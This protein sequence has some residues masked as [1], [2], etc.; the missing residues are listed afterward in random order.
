M[1]P[2][3]NSARVE[4]VQGIP[5]DPNTMFV[6]F[7]SGGLWKTENG[8]LSWKPIFEEN[9]SPGIGD[10]AIA[11]SNPDIIYVGTGESLKKPRN[12]TMPGTGM[13]RSTDGGR[14]W[15]HLGLTETRHISEIS[16]HPT[17]PD[18]VLVA[19]MGNFWTKNADRGIYR[20]SDSGKTWKQVLYVDDKTSGNDVV[21][22]PSN[23]DI[24]YASLWENDPKYSRHL[25]PQS[26]GLSG[27][28]SGVFKSTD[29]GLTWSK[30]N[31]G[32][33]ENENAGRI[34]FGV[35]Y[36]DA[37]KVYAFL[38]HR[39]KGIL[40]GAGELYKTES[41]GKNW[42]KTHKDE[43][44]NLSVIGWYFVDT[45]VNPQD[46][47]E[48]YTLGVR[49]AN[50]RDGGKTFANIGGK[51]YHHYPS[52]AQTLHLD[53][54]EMWINPIDP[55]H[56]IL[57]NDGGVYV[58]TDRGE[59]WK[60]LNNIPTGEFYDITIDNQDPYLIY[61]GTQDNSTVYGPALEWNSK[62]P[63][64]WKYLWIDA[65]SG[66]DGC[67]TFVDP[68]DPKRVYFSMQ[69][70]SIR[71]KD[72]EADTSISIRPKLPDSLQGKFR[73]NFIT[74]YLLSPNNPDKLYLAGN[75]VF[76]SMDQ[77][78]SWNIISSDLSVSSNERKKSHAASAF[79][80]SQ[81]QKGTLYLGTDMGAFWISKDD[82]RTWEERSNGLPNAY[83]RSIY[84]SNHGQN[85]IYLAATGLNYDDLSPYL[86]VTEDMGKGWI[87]IVGN[88]PSEPVNVVHE[89]P[90]FKDVL[91]AGT[92]RGI[93]VSRN[94]GASWSYLG[95]NMP[96]VA[97]ADIEIEPES[98][99]MITAT[100][101]RGIYK[102]NLSPIYEYFE[103]EG[104]VL[105]TI[106][107]AI[108]PKRTD[109][110]ND[111]SERTFSRVPITYWS[112]TEEEIKLE[113]LDQKDSL[114]WST[115]QSATVGLN[116]FR[117][118]LITQKTES[119]SPYFIHYNKF[120]EPG[121]YT[122]VLTQADQSFM[123]ELVVKKYEN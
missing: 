62:F 42:I 22:S 72:I 104:R 46:D 61:G 35:S 54:C 90:K 121:E 109:T 101:G 6:A 53:H 21:I 31:N 74:P 91:Y 28:N 111:Y 107:E 77:G 17:N 123:R 120:I 110:H 26:R 48:I 112:D 89:D 37:D 25:S 4:S 78:T 100:H 115:S 86:F 79:T 12:F 70:G 113:I 88:L 32:I 117:W 51:I 2:T 95:K 47:N 58:T 59:T 40:K 1:G 99:D 8:G 96:S 105:F 81:K 19:A 119:N 118:D 45:Y 93:Y 106:P 85:R 83:I 60:H 20:T 84:P 102:M 67:M 56:Q 108:L 39:N 29:G 23:P 18:I 3:L 64:N 103:N 33:P 52:P 43:L 73:T 55:H 49:L 66:G 7:G 16:V 34:G 114:I 9:P 68:R 27:P 24:V 69:H 5:D 44:L 14:S 38:D 76:K 75:Y 65:W 50:S 63:D 122:V 71:K 116:Q 41:G 57:G 80:E 87:S 11:P 15:I 98:N 10:I 97:V 36:Q 13:Y 94:R 30:M 92:L 82:G